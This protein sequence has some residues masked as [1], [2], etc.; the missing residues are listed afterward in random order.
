MKKLHGT[1]CRQGFSY[2]FWLRY[3]HIKSKNLLSVA[4]FL[5]QYLTICLVWQKQNSIIGVII[6]RMPQNQLNA[7]FEDFFPQYFGSV[8][9]CFVENIQFHSHF[10]NAL[11]EL[12]FNYHLQSVAIDF[13]MNF[14]T[15]IF[16]NEVF[17]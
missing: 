8:I 14:N 15:L 3:F 10:T 1:D 9:Y 5:V 17:G 6:F 11:P 16:K 2:Y 12:W 4:D 7:F 13:C